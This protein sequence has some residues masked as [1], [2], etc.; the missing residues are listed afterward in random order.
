MPDPPPPCNNSA[1]HPL[2]CQEEAAAPLGQAHLL[3]AVNDAGAGHQV[4]VGDV[5]PVGNL[6]DAARV[7]RHHGV[8]NVGKLAVL[9]DEEIWV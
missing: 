3:E 6:V 1:V 8:A 5:G 9:K 4:R 7:L 2:T